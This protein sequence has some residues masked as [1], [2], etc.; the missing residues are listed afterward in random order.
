[1]IS[2]CHHHRMTCYWI[3]ITSHIISGRLECT[4]RTCQQMEKEL[5]WWKSYYTWKLILWH[6][7]KTLNNK[8][9]RDRSH[10]KDNH[11]KD[12]VSQQFHLHHIVTKSNILRYLKYCLVVL[13]WP[14]IISRCTIFLLSWY[15]LA[16]KVL[17]HLLIFALAVL[18]LDSV[19]LH[20]LFRAPFGVCQGYVR[21][22]SK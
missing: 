7:A 16:S 22:K 3:Y 1:M 21:D 5:Y 12:I 8:L 13:I 20:W 10:T 9:L 15:K 2:W 17:Y 14:S 19:V 4:D 6:N 18:V 11:R